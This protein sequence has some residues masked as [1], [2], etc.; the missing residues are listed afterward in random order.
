MVNS[1]RVERNIPIKMRDGVTLRAD[2]CRPDDNEK[3]PAIVVRT[4]YDKGPSM[5][6]DYLSPIEAA[7]AGYA[8]VIQDTR[9]RFASEGDF[10]P[11][12]PE[13]KDGYDTIENVAAESW[14][15]GNVGMVGAS[16][17]GRNQWQAAIEAPPHL[18]A[19][20]PHVIGAGMLGESGMSG[21]KELETALSWSA[22]MALD[23]LARMAKQGK[24]VSEALASV[25]YAMTNF[26]EVCN[27]LPLKDMPYF[28]FEGLQEGFMR[29]FSDENLKGIKSE[30]E[31]FW[32]YEKV[33]VPIMQSCGWYDMSPGHTFLNFLKMREK[34]G[35]QIA[36]EGQ[37]L[38]MGPWVHGARLH[39]FI[40]ALNFGPYGSGAGA[41]AT[42]RHIQFFDKYLKG[43]DSPYLVPIRYFVMGRK[44][45]RNATTWPLPETR[46]QRFYLHSR[47][48]ANSA[49]GDGVFSREEPGAESPDIYVYNPHDLK[50]EMEITGP[51]KL[52]LFA[53]TSTKDT[54]FFVKMVDVYPNGLAINVAEGCI[55]ARYRKSILKS[56]LVTPGEINEY[57]IDLASTSNLF[58]KGHHIRI[59]ITSSNFPRFER[60]MNT[61]NPFGED[62]QGIPA[63]QT[64]FHHSGYASYIDLPVISL[65]R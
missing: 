19:I 61:G 34:G 18:K 36:R 1:I 37:H 7:F 12:A 55:R 41:F 33:R 3:H 52:H 44:R 35:S 14:C 54:D 26:E 63:M 57:L 27:F 39:N 6:S 20:A 48:H 9:G 58:G 49:G 21:V 16:Y 53:S 47:G 24:D 50:E 31:L 64:I 4:P 40:G 32:P 45:W 38:L 17:L 15:D 51:L 29:R 5:R 10:V 25:R 2:V 13:G 60:N 43:I 8:V 23:T 22:N 30:E 28:K 56:Q 11:G 59:D 46:W 62:A 42:S 65:T